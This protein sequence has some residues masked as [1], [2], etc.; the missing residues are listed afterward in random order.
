MATQT[1]TRTTVSGSGRSTLTDTRR[2]T[3]E[4]VRMA[5][6]PLGG[7]VPTFGVL[8]VAPRHDVAVAL[9]VAEGCAP[10]ATFLACTTAGEI[11]ERGLTRDGVAALVVSSPD[12]AVLLRTATGREG[13]SGGRG[14]EAVRRL[15]GHREGRGRARPQAA[16]TTVLLVDG[17][18]GAGE[19][20]V[21]E[22]MSATRSFQQVVGGAAG[23]DGAF[24]ATTGGR[25]RQ[26]ASPTARLPSTRS[27]AW[28]GAWASTTASR[29]PA[30]RDARHPGLA[31]RRP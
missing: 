16:S 30:Q 21:N 9:G 2:A 22:I 11:T 6:K 1:Q 13:R 25:R 24:K 29:P 19:E 3:E 4:A 20:L 5:L 14:P 31:Q 23:D 12:T 7:G 17:L 18:N 26:G 28:R 10:G 27:H 15:R 8:F